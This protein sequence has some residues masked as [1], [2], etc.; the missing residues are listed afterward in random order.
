MACHAPCIYKRDAARLER[1]VEILESGLG[2]EK[3][4]Q[5]VEVEKRGRLNAV[6]DRDRL[7]QRLEEREEAV[8]KLKETIEYYKD[9]LVWAEEAAEK[10]KASSDERIR[11]LKKQAGQLKK[12]LSDAQWR[13]EKVRKDLA[14]QHEKEL[15][16]QKASYE[17]RIMEM[18]GKYQAELAEKDKR[19]R[20]LTEH[21]QEGVSGKDGKNPGEGKTITIEKPKTDSTTSSIPPGQDPNHPTITNN[22]TPS[23]RK[24]GAQDGHEAHPRKAY[25]PTTVIV[26]PPPREVLEHPDDYYAI[27]PISKQVV[28]VRLVVEVTEYQGMKYRNHKTR[29]IIHSEFPEDVG[30]LEVNYDPSIDALATY[31]HSV[32]NVPYN[33]IQELLREATEGNS[34]DISTGKLADLEKKFSGLTGE[35]RA[36]IAE[37]LFRGRSMNIDG[38]GA[39]VD[40]RQRQ[41]LIMCNK[42]N[43]LFRM[44][45]CKGEKAVEG[46]PAEEYQGVTISDSETTFTRLG[47]KNQRCNIHESRYLKRASLNTPDLTWSSR[48]REFLQRIQHERNV[49]L[50]QGK[51]CMPVR[52]R[53]KTS[54]EYDSCLILGISEYREHF[55]ELFRNHL[56]RSKARLETCAERYG[57]DTDIASQAGGGAGKMRKDCEIYPEMPADALNALIKDINLLIRLMA[58]KEH[59]LLF[60]EDYSIPPHN[61]DAEKCA[62]TVKTHLKPN[63]GM[64]SEE[65]AGYYADTA[66]VLETEHRQGK[67]RLVKLGE[68][69]GRSV[70][71]IKEKMAEGCKKQKALEATI[72]GE[73]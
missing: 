64:R 40:G 32:C 26:L 10:E 60:L 67:S 2:L 31:L 8:R 23:G 53:K 73:A 27:G 11:S 6:N 18:E 63:G 15:K 72:P 69:F 65:Y 51:R 13:L 28:S 41:V 45:G 22:R 7:K 62:R 35:E 9:R 21:L 4:K 3:L 58:D 66:S 19:I 70:K 56:V 39:R 59:Y 14:K 1:R 50:E 42:E 46:T 30:H 61:N 20:L 37:R 55:P 36:D 34:L 47:G 33:K 71:A 48:M 52:E 38:T 43:V 44:T 54:S 12:A 16:Q 29:E 49:G 57:I 25:Q 24:P 5:A 68:V 17:A